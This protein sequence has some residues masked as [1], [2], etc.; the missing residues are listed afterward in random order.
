MY[1]KNQCR[2]RPRS[3][4]LGNKYTN[5]CAEEKVADIP[6]SVILNPETLAKHSQDI[7][8]LNAKRN[9][10]VT[11]LT[12][13]EDNDDWLDLSDTESITS[14]TSTSSSRVKKYF[15]SYNNCDKGFTR[16]SLLTHH[17]QT[18]HQ[19]LRPFKCN[20]CDKAFARKN[21]LDRHLASHMEDKDKPFHCSVCSKGC[22]TQQQLKRHEITHTK[23]F[24]CEYPDCNES[25]YKHPQLRS[26]VLSFHL[27]KLKCDKC[28]KQFQRP[29]RLRHHV[30]KYHNPNNLN[31]YSCN[32]SS[33]GQSFKTWT[34][35]QTHIKNDHPKLSCPICHKYLVGEDGLK[36][37]MKIHDDSIIMKKNW[38]CSI[39]TD[40]KFNKK[41]DL[42]NHYKETHKDIPFIFQ[43]DSNNDSNNEI[44]TVNETNGN[45][46]NVKPI[47]INNEINNI[48]NQVNLETYLGNEN[49]SGMKLLL[50]TVGRK[51][52]CTFKGCHRSFKSQEK[53]EIH[54]N[55]HKI[56][57]LKLRVLEEKNGKPI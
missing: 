29:Y 2:Q 18:V 14:T 37:H 22:I 32:F 27:H 7:A 6:E 5:M 21:H 26:H 15:C 30:D 25:F 28:G 39:C 49:N 1:L 43:N 24:K 48:Q 17:Q 12:T 16:P 54:L 52:K 33:C 20:Q 36:M 23:S 50:N 9:T 45:R 19:G 38:N 40:V 8:T 34:N 41:I 47:V 35:L 31:P 13:P 42:L 57:L 11:P 51:F 4:E 56:H 53:F 46:S 44:Q 3:W 55:K 10:L